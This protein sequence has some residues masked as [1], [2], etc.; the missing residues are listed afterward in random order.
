M[1][2]SPQI[3]FKLPKHLKSLVITANMSVVDRTFLL[4]INQISQNLM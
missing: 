3:L 4:L 1:I 2:F